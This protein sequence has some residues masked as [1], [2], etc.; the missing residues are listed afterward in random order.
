MPGSQRVVPLFLEISINEEPECLEYVA[1]DG[2]ILFS[3]VTDPSP[4]VKTR[5]EA[6]CACNYAGADLENAE[7]FNDKADGG[8]ED[9]NDDE[10]AVKEQ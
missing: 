2:K 5:V 1:G 4:K 10:G 9:E 6:L 8:E 7:Y 3:L